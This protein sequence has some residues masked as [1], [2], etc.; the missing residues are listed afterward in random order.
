MF[1]L[2]AFQDVDKRFVESLLTKHRSRA[3]VAAA[4]SHCEL[5][6]QF[7]YGAQEIRG[8]P[9]LSYESRTRRRVISSVTVLPFAV[10]VKFATCG[11]GD[12]DTGSA[13]D[14]LT[15]FAGIFDWAIA[16]L[17]AA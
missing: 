1:M 13:Q 17:I 10:T 7:M 14:T 2:R 15:F 6:C 9:T 3:R 4:P 12:S 8:S 11:V 5:M 16:S